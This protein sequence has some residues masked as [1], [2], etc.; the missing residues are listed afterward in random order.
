[1]Q[2]TFRKKRRMKKNRRKKQWK[3][4]QECGKKASKAT[5]TQNRMVK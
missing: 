3:K 1:M 2:R 4:S 5:R